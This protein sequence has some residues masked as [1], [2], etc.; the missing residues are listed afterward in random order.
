MRRLALLILSVLLLSVPVLGE[1]NGPY[2]D[3]SDAELL[4]MLLELRQELLERKLT[5]SSLL[6][7]GDYTVGQ[8]IMPG[9]YLFNVAEAERSGFYI[10]HF[11]NSEQYAKARDGGM[12]TV[13]IFDSG[14]VEY[15]LEKG[16]PRQFVLEE[17]HIIRF[18]SGICYIEAVDKPSWAP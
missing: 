1:S 12:S 5:E 2:I 18:S 11:R 8:D 17:G 3:K 15:F 10:S 6:Y 16:T 14:G 13:A 9:A 4:E 7:P